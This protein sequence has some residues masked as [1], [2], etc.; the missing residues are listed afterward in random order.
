MMVIEA[1]KMEHAVVA[2]YAGCVSAIHYRSGDRVTEGA[3]LVEVLPV[4]DAAAANCTV[5]A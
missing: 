5:R 2:P 4:E 3:R 1:M